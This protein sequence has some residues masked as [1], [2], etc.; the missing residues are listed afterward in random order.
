MPE[1]FSSLCMNQ[2]CQ[3]QLYNNLVHDGYMK[4]CVFFSY[5]LQ[6]ECPIA[7]GLP[8]ICFLNFSMQGFSE[9]LV[10]GS[11]PAIGLMFKQVWFAMLSFML[12]LFFFKYLRNFNWENIK[13]VPLQ[14]MQFWS[15][16]LPNSE[17]KMTLITKG[18]SSLKI[19]HSLP[20]HRDTCYTQK[21]SG[22]MS[23]EQGVL[24]S[25]TE[26]ELGQARLGSRTRNFE[27]ETSEPQ[28]E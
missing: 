6:L 4:T 13:T 15:S 11:R 17:L 16:S 5:S 2:A 23:H 25:R 10:T 9:R 19:F 26:T 7:S 24:R 27:L 14:C 20:C 8:L 1:R 12:L 21:I 28:L 22:M 18:P 3:F